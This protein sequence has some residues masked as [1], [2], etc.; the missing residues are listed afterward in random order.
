MYEEPAELIEVLKQLHAQIRDA[1]V[2]ACEAQATEA[3]SE[4]A[5]DD[6]S[7]DTIYAMKV[8]ILFRNIM[9]TRSFAGH[10]Q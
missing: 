5:D 10:H 4:I 9:D 6:A 3:L 8:R 2:A 1:V 7:G